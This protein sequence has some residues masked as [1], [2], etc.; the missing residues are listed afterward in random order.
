MFED[1]AG[2][3]GRWLGS[4][5]RDMLGFFAKLALY[6]F[7]VACVWGLPWERILSKAGFVGKTYWTLFTLIVFP[8]WFFPGFF[9]WI[10]ADTPAVKTIGEVSGFAVYGAFIFVAIAPWP[11]RK[12]TKAN[13]LAHSS[14]TKDLA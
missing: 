1:F 11:V 13:A 14:T 5:T 10:G 2:E 4:M 3:L 12:K 8:V 6:T 7:M 9:A